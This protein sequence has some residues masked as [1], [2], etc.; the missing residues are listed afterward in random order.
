[1][2]KGDDKWAGPYVVTEIYPRAC[3]V[4]LPE[5][6][7]IFPVFHNHL[8]HR[9]DHDATG[10][11]GQDII[12]EVESRHIRGRVLEREDRE[13]E[14]VEKWEFE[15]LLDCHNEDGLHYLVKWRHHA[16]TWQPAKDLRGQNEVLLEFHRQNPDK[17]GPPS[18]VR[19]PKPEQTPVEARSVEENRPAG[20]S[21]L[22]SLGSRLGVSFA[23]TLQAIDSSL[24]YVYAI[25]SISFLHAIIC[26]LSFPF[27][28]ALLS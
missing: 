2:K 1:M 18:W 24:P 28:R 9:K 26:V 19:R 7:R 20:G 4:Q 22:H 11:P 12:N 17:P 10:L 25:S 6:V 14:P 3:R 21:R 8:L 5:R 13:V 27:S 23:P 16:A 15:K